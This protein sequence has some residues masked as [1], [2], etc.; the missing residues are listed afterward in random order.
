MRLNP[1]LLLATSL[2]ASGCFSYVPYSPQEVA[3]GDPVRFRLTAE[4]AARYQDLRL[5]NPRLIEGTLVRRGDSD[6]VL[7]AHVGGT[8]AMEGSRLMVQQVSIPLSEILEVELRELDRTKTVL[9][10]VGGGAALATVLALSGHGFGSE[11]GPGTEAPEA[12]RIPLIRFS[13]PLAGR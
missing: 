1:L 4:E 5:A 2:A 3:P 12:R 11:E 7:D 13:I 6:M 8:G 10:S 9:V